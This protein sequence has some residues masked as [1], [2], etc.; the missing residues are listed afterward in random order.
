[1]ISGPD[2][3]VLDLS[4]APSLGTLLIAPKIGMLTLVDVRPHTRRDG[5]ASV[6]LTW[7]HKDGRRFTSGLRTKSLGRAKVAP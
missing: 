3:Y 4:E 5:A 1:M 2:V 7:A 6:I